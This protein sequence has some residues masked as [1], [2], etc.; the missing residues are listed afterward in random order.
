[1]K[2]RNAQTNVNVRTDHA[3]HMYTSDVDK[4]TIHRSFFAPI[5]EAERAI[6]VTCDPAETTKKEF[7]SLYQD[8]IILELKEI[9]DLK[10]KLDRGT[11]AR[12]IVDAG[13]LPNQI[14]T[15][16]ERRERFIDSL[17]KKYPLS[18]L[19][20]YRAADLTRDTL[21]QLAAFH[22]KLHLTTSDFTLI[23]GDYVDRSDVSYDS[24]NRIVRDDLEA[25]ILSLLQKRAMCGFEII[26]AVNLEFNVLLSPGAVYPLLNTLR[27]RGLITSFRE[28]KEKIYVPT[29]G[30]KAEIKRIVHDQIRA[31]T[32][33][34]SYLQ[35]NIG[36]TSDEA[37]VESAE[38]LTN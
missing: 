29:D 1:M 32:L 23:S 19:C 12:L 26:G 20:T 10:S 6:I 8:L 38:G 2:Q 16:F 5:T 30:S 15:E 17:S 35:K 7:G 3:L 34:N 22:G 36:S 24:L 25:I 28:G 31:R 9:H 21:R 13:S 11:R 33:L 27:S 4:Y 37:T 14:E 18:C